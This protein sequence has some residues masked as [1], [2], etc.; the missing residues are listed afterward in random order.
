MQLT[1]FHTAQQRNEHP[2]A[3]EIRDAVLI[4]DAERPRSKQ[5]AI[6]ASD[7][8]QPCLRR[9][10]YRL[11]NEP[12]IN[13]HRTSTWAAI[14]GTAVHESLA[15][16]FL[17]ANNRAGRIRYLV[18]QRIKIRGNIHGTL[19]LYD[20]DRATIVD[21]KIVGISALK[22]YK[23]NGPAPAYRVQVHACG[24]GLKQ[25]GLP[26]ETVAIAFYPRGH[27][28]ADLHV[29]DEPY[30]E[31]VVTEAL[32]RHDHLIEL[33]CELDVEHHPDRYQIIPKTPSRLCHYCP[34]WKG[35]PDTGIGCPGNTDT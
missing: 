18:E 26:V 8:G 29:W 21:N 14:V 4:A 17:A 13:T 10:A 20:G 7:L 28:I 15:E 25:L 5:A 23:R 22:E 9:L 33:I 16:A 35:G 11:M 24:A 6:G 19:D 12:T 1:E 2:L 3:S 34:W 31:N 32:T 30:D 27:D